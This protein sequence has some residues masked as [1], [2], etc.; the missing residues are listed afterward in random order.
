M[1]EGS[2]EAMKAAELETVRTYSK[3]I[4]E[5]SDGV[6]C[7]ESDN[8]STLHLQGRLNKNNLY[9]FNGTFMLPSQQPPVGLGSVCTSTALLQTWYRRVSHLDLRV[10]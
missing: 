5:F 9:S 1:R 2:T 6:A 7:M 4:P 10:I 8:G 3:P